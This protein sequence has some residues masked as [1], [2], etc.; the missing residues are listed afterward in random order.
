MHFIGAATL[1]ADDE[2]PVS[3]LTRTFTGDNAPKAGDVA[4]ITN[5]AKEFVYVSGD[6]ITAGWLELGDESQHATKSELSTA[7]EQLSSYVNEKAAT[8]HAELTAEA[9]AREDADKA[10]AADI[11]TLSSAIDGK[12]SVG[13]YANGAYAWRESSDLSVVKIGTDDYHQMVAAG[14]VDNNIVYVVSSDNINAYGERIIEVAEPVE[15]TDAATKNYVDTTIETATATIKSTSLSG[16][17]VN[18]VAATVIDNVASFQIDLIDCGNA[19]TTDL[20]I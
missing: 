10:T 1:S 16:V 7:R 3:C 6:G 11:K 17:S 2:D 15:K 18:G 8:A 14:T 19:N 4:I 12:L 20:T 5:T 9:K 13:D